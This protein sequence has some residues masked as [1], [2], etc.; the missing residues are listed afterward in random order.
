MV[1]ILL[2]FFYKLEYKMSLAGNFCTSL[3][4]FRNLYNILY[5]AETIIFLL[6]FDIYGLSGINFLFTV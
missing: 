2:G 5:K 3:Y 1:K 6:R 4:I